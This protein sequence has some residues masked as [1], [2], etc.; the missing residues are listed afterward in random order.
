MNRSTGLTPISRTDSYAR[1]DLVLLESR[2]RTLYTQVTQI[3]ACL[4][5]PSTNRQVV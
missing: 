1:I 3:D 5:S 2:A 4:L